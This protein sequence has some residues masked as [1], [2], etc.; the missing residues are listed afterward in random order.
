[1][2]LTLF[3][4]SGKQKITQRDET[5]SRELAFS[6]LNNMQRAVVRRK[7]LGW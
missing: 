7:R 1:V 2:L 6:P 5:V 3:E 4:L